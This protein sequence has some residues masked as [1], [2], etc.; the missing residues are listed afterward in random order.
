VDRKFATLSE[1]IVNRL[2][3]KIK[4]FKSLFG[5]FVFDNQ[6]RIQHPNPRTHQALELYPLIA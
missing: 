4:E 3:Q 6:G 5:S 1:L 2:V